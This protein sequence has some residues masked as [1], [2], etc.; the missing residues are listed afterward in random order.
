LDGGLLK[1]QLKEN[2]EWTQQQTLTDPT[3][4]SPEDSQTV[5]HNPSITRLD[6]SEDQMRVYLQNIL[7]MA[8]SSAGVQLK[9]NKIVVDN[10]TYDLVVKMNSAIGQKLSVRENSTEQPLAELSSTSLNIYDKVIE[11][12]GAGSSLKSAV[13]LEQLLSAK[14]QAIQAKGPSNTAFIY[15]V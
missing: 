2:G 11:G 13:N 4:V 7:Y 5:P 14:P 6:M 8:V 1:Y 15:N 10:A 9:A 3:I 12:V